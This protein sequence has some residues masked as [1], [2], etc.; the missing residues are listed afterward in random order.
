V[1]ELL[2][3]CVLALT[4]TGAD[5]QPIG[6][7]WSGAGRAVG[8]VVAVLVASVLVAVIRAGGSRK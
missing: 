1:S 5:T 7:F 3:S 4:Q 6:G 8:I 2:I